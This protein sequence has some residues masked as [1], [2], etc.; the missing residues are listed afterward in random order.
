MCSKPQTV[1]TCFTNSLAVKQQFREISLFFVG[2][3]EI[4]FYNAIKFATNEHIYE[5]YIFDIDSHRPLENISQNCF[6]TWNGQHSVFV[7][8]F[9]CNKLEVKS[10]VS[11]NPSFH[12][13]ALVICMHF[14][15]VV[16]AEKF[17]L[18]KYREPNSKKNILKHALNAHD[19]DMRVSRVEWKHRITILAANT[20]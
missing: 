15:F 3:L 20:I 4:F 9:K 12:V 11:Q 14:S 8:K 6:E 16:A 18:H 10:N 17:L 19:N 1:F 2:D 7:W 5:Q 13:I